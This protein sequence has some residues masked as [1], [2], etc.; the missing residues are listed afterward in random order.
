M[1]S[2]NLIMGARNGA[3]NEREQNDFYATH[4]HATE[5]FLRK[6]EKDGVTLHKNVWECACGRGHMAD[7][8]KQNGYNV[9]ATDLIDRKYGET[10]DFLTQEEPFNGDIITNPPYKS[11]KEFCYKGLEL[12]Q[13]NNYVIMFLKIQFLEGKERKKLFEK[14]PPKYIYIN[15]ERQHCAM[16]GDFITYNAKTQAYIWVIWQKGYTG[17]TIT[18]W[19]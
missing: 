6:L 9:R 5:I 15:S 12:A 8:F 17:E 3:K 10:L 11:A 18:R 13:D 7:V 1:K 14:Y 16:N 2:L 4:P 19:I